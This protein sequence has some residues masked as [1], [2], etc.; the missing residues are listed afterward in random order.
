[1]LKDIIK[2][3]TAMA[4]YQVAFI[5]SLTW[6]LICVAQDDFPKPEDFNKKPQPIPQKQMETWVLKSKV[7]GKSV[8]NEKSETVGMAEVV[9]FDNKTYRMY[10]GASI[11]AGQTSINYAE[12]KDAAK[13]T[14]K[15]AVLKGTASARDRE[16]LISGPSVLKLPD[17]RFRMYYQSSPQQTPNMPPK[18]HVR[19]AI[20]A[21]GINFTREEGVRI[22]I[23]PYDNTS[24]LRLAGHGTYFIA[25]DGTYVVIF[26]GEFLNDKFGPSDLKIGF[27]KDGLQFSNFKT[28][29]T[30]WHDPI[31]LKEKNGYRIYATYMLEKQG[32]AFSEDGLTWPSEMTEVTFQDPS[33]KKLTEGNTGIGDIGGVIM[34][35]GNIR[36]FT[37]YGG[38]Y[39]STDIVYFDKK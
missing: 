31:V 16:N 24:G 6:I 2:G 4:K 5:L 9:L 11:Q 3:E 37:N 12:S 10:Y 20:S 14:V 18:Y 13:W 8:K 36:L 26:S 1:M 22:D 7:I 28:L 38:T 29:Y 17:G 35:N 34:A 21:D 32:T 30:D 19:S 33:G 25:A 39:A 23:V 15:G 27:S